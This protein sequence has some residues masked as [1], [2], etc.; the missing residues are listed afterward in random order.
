MLG[1]PAEEHRLYPSRRFFLAG[2]PSP[3]L[4]AASPERAT[5]P[6]NAP[7]VP[8]SEAPVS[9]AALSPPAASPEAA[10]LRPASSSFFCAASLSQKWCKTQFFDA[11]RAP[12][13]CWRSGHFGNENAEFPAISRD[14]TKS[15][16]F[17]FEEPGE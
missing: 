1:T 9:E 4:L 16:E 5:A 13:G 10:S 15:G 3:F 8:L 12:T 17:F 7:E 6:Q 2:T 14:K 11:P